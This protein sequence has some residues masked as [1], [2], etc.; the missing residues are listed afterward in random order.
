ME[1]EQKKNNFLSFIEEHIRIIATSAIVLAIASFLLPILKV[2]DTV[3][4][5]KFN[6]HLWNYF[7]FAHKYDFVMIVIL[8][9]LLLAIGFVWLAKLRND[10]G[11]ASSLAI[12]IAI[13]L[14]I[15]LKELYNEYEG[16]SASIGVGLA[17]AIVFMVLAMFLVLS[18][19]YK[20]DKMTVRDIAEEAILIALAFVF[21]FIKIGIGSTGGSIN[22]QMLPLFILAL[23][24]GPSHGLIAGGII[25]G[26]FTCLTDG[27]GFACYPFDYL[28]GFGSI[29]VIGWFRSLIIKPQDKHY[30]FRGE[31]FLF[32]ACILS[33]A[34]RFIGSTMSSMIIWDYELLPAMSYNVLY[35]VPS[36]LAAMVVIMVLLGPIVIINKKFPVKKDRLIDEE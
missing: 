25:Y 31:L 19:N 34:V 3:N 22:F 30:T 26:L 36:G 7:S 17:L 32:I 1:Q 21:N 10:L 2:K 5:I 8:V 14:T 33:T 12:A 13:P 29:A 27:Y 23:R 4:D 20:F 28:I 6:V 35:I 18:V 11:T 16:Y 24:H 9:L 15:I